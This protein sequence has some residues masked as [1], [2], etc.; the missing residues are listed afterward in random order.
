[1]RSLSELVAHLTKNQITNNVD[2]LVNVD[3]MKGFVTQR[4]DFLP[5]ELKLSENIFKITSFLTS[6]FFPIRNENCGLKM[7]K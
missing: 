2:G 5:K 3:D 6:V 7:V 1:M 4:Q